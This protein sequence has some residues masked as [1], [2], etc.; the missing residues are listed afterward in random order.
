MLEMTHALIIDDNRNN[1][2]V[3]IM[4]LEL[5]GVGHTAVQ[6]VKQLPGA[7]DGLDSLDVVFLD[8]EFPRG[9]GFSLLESLKETAQFDGVPVVAYTVHTSEINKARLAGFDGFL[10]KPLNMQ[11]FPEQLRHILNGT[12]V[13]DV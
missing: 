11:R 13:W 9:D 7:L 8:L 10:G 4:L 6:S 2:D 3:L 12:P 5:E 1:I